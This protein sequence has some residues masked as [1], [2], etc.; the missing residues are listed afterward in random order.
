MF[1]IKAKRQQFIG[2]CKQTESEK[3]SIFGLLQSAVQINMLGALWLAVDPGLTNHK[4]AYWFA[5]G[6][7][8]GT[9]IYI[10]RDSQNF[11]LKSLK[12]FEQNASHN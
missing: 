9:P 10:L 4:Q 11:Y 1:D 7:P 2:N 5:V 6:I 3:S 12:F 8:Q